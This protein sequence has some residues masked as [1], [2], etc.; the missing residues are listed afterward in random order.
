M[1]IEHLAD[2]LEFVQTL[3]EWHYREWRHLCPGETLDDFVERLRGQAQRG[4]VPT[5]F[6]ALEGGRPVGS[7]SLVAH[8]MQGREDLS[9]WLASVYVAPPCRRRGIGSA[10]VRRVVQ[11]AGERHIPTIYLYTTG[12]ANENFY[13][14]LGWS[15]R[16]RVEYVGKL[17]VIM[18]I[19]A[20]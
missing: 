2:H 8:D 12:K 20:S 4:G 11:E 9:P 14:H 18:E 15:V 10:L 6:V 19:R 7:A 5:A 13:V 17:R 1:R 16:E 3:A